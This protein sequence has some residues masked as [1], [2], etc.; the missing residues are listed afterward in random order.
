[1]VLTPIRGSAR[2][3]R[4]GP[5][6]TDRTFRTPPQQGSP[7]AEATQI[8]ARRVRR[9]RRCPGGRPAD[10]EVARGGVLRRQPESTTAPPDCRPLTILSP[11]L[12]PTA[13]GAGWRPFTSASKRAGQRGYG[14]DLPPTSTVPYLSG[15][16][17]TALIC[18][19]AYELNAGPSP[20]PGRGP[21]I[22]RRKTR[23]TCGAPLRNRPSPYHRPPERRCTVHMGPDQPCHWLRAAHVSV[24]WPPGAAICPLSCPPRLSWRHHPSTCSDS[25]ADIRI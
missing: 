9:D 18:D 7:S 17:T 6:H 19:F 12:P 4:M 10:L 24:H 23:L 3:P 2:F 1:M 8:G 21:R 5:A 22:G 15:N 25:R 13:P 16:D 14:R 11:D 20:G